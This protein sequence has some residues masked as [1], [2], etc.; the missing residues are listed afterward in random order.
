MLHYNDSAAF[1][2]V[3]QGGMLGFSNRFELDPHIREVSLF[4]LLVIQS[5]TSAAALPSE[6]S[7]GRYVLGSGQE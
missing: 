5:F 3:F 2:F 7:C 4:D 6:S 1:G